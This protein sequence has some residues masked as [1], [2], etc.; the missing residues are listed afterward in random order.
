LKIGI[1]FE[2]EFLGVYPSLINAINLLSPEAKEIEIISS[3]RLSNFAKPPKFPA[4]VSY[5]KIKQFVCYNRNAFAKSGHENLPFNCESPSKWKAFLPESFKKWYRAKRAFILINLE[6]FEEQKDWFEDK[7]R[8]LVFCIKRYLC[9]DFD[10]IIAVDGIGIVAA[11]LISF[12]CR[13]K[14]LII[15]WSLEID[16][17]QSPQISQ[18]LFDYFTSKA[19]KVADTLVIQ[20]KSRLK[21]LCEKFKFNV[22]QTSIFLVPHSPV[23]SKST[24]TKSNFFQRKFSF[25]KSDIVILHAGWIHDAMCV[26]KIAESSKYWKEEYKLVLHEREKRSDTEP[27]IRHVISLSKNRVFL[28]LDPVSF[29]LIDEVFSSATIGIIAYDKRYGEGRENAHKASGKLGQYLKCGIP[30]IAL[31]LPGYSEM[32]EE[33]RCGMVFDDFSDIESCVDQILADYQSFHLQALRC[34]EEEFDF[35]KFFNPLLLHIHRSV[36]TKLI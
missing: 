3:K 29:D 26:D 7:V 18:R 17:R 30:V 8:Y 20:E 21:A 33:Y 36:S 24:S 2:E 19:T 11:Y 10:A 25:S 27:F 15:F 14:P 13:H 4:N 12:F 5:S 6:N 32:F 34:F 23:A 28:S 31:N 35:G 16:S 9:K 1:L 22:N